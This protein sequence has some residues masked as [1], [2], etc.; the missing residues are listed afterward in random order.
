MQGWQESCRN[1]APSLSSR[2]EFS[3]FTLYKENFPAAAGLLLP[4]EQEGWVLSRLS[5]LAGLISL[6]LGTE[7]LKGDTFRPDFEISWG[8]YDMIVQ[9]WGSLGLFGNAENP[10]TNF[11]SSA[12]SAQNPKIQAER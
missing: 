11:F 9:G 4:P 5:F 1:P 3:L 2:I 12:F 8:I 10:E 7:K 6:V